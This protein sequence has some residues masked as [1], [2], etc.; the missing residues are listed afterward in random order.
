M[1]TS[2]VLTGH[3]IDWI[4]EKGKKAATEF[5]RAEKCRGTGAVAS[6]DVFEAGALSWYL[7]PRSEVVDASGH[8]KGNRH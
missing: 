8:A 4:Y 1:F 3:R 6:I 2:V 7:K 5:A